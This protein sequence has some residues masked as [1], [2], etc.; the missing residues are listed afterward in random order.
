MAY[1][2]DESK[3]LS[4]LEKHGADFEDVKAFEWDTAVIE[5]SPRR[6]EPRWIATGYIADRLHCIVFTERGERRRIISLRKANP[7][8]E[9]NYAQA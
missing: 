1:E 2:W 5:P 9:R 7:R 3:R 4:N 8:E 6:G